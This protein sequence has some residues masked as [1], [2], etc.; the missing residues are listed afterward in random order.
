MP[1][2]ADDSLGHCALQRAG[3][4]SVEVASRGSVG[5]PT[6]SV[7]AATFGEEV[8]IKWCPRR[9][10]NPHAPKDNAF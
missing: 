1:G 10:S 2:R 7:P 3:S 4:S 9:D 8:M 6:M 5:R